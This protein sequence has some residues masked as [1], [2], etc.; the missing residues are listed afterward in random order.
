MDEKLKNGNPDKIRTPIFLTVCKTVICTRIQRHYKLSPKSWRN[1]CTS[2][3]GQSVRGSSSPIKNRR[4]AG[5]YEN[6]RP[7]IRCLFSYSQLRRST[8][9]LVCESVNTLLGNASRIS[10]TSARTSLPFSSLTLD[11]VPRSMPR[12]PEHK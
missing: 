3:D 7:P 6:F 8:T 12:T 1:L 4:I 9:Y 5:S 2:F 11:A 10:S